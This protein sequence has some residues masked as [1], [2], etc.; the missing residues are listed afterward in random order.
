MLES[1]G[2]W[3]NKRG[4]LAPLLCF[5]NY[6]QVVDFLKHVLENRN[7]SPHA[8]VLP[9]SIYISLNFV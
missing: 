2:M 3:Q 8:G 9:Q 4:N 7:K 6:L 1:L 5:L